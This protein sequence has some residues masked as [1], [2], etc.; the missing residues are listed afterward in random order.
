MKTP[1]TE[2]FP[3][4]EWVT[5]DEELSR[6]SVHDYSLLALGEDI[7]GNEYSG[8][9]VMC[10]GELIR[11][12]Q[13]ELEVEAKEVIMEMQ[14]TIEGNRVIVEFMGGIV[15][16]HLRS[17]RYP[18]HLPS[19]A[20]MLY[21]FDPLKIGGYDYHTSWE[22]LMPVVERVESL[23]DDFHGYFGVS[24]YSNS[25]TIQGTRLNTSS[26]SFHPAYL[27]DPNA[28]F[29]TKIESTWYNIVSFIKWY[30]VNILNK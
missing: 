23:H 13:I 1:A 4:I 20:T 30:N 24:I 18:K 28:I 12:D 5:T 25:C 26:E 22:W 2:E 10:D 29:P 6:E 19:W 27:S 15:D 7:K 11:I 21:D 16:D 14:E 8:A 3:E 17:K 9:A